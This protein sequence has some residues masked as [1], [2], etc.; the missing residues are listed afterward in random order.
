MKLLKH[1]KAWRFFGLHFYIS[2]YSLRP[3]GQNNAR[4]RARRERLE[5]VGY[6]CEGCGCE[7]DKYNSHVFRLL[8]VT[9]DCTER[10]KVENVRVYC[11]RC[12]R[13]A[14]LELSQRKEVRR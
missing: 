13:L 4:A 7:L 9:A 2:P 10:H 3:K 11:A 5:F 1:M 12:N 8:P 14:N 6:K